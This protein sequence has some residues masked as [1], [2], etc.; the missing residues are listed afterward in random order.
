MHRLW[1][2]KVDARLTQQ[3]R[4][5]LSSNNP[6]LHSSILLRQQHRGH[7]PIP[8]GNDPD[9]GATIRQVGRLEP[10]SIGKGTIVSGPA[11]RA[12]GSPIPCLVAMEPWKWQVEHSQLGRALQKIFAQTPSLWWRVNLPRGAYSGG[13]SMPNHAPQP[14]QRTWEP[15][16]PTPFK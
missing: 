1:E 6:V 8:L 4:T 5:S 12:N 14:R 16:Q 11:L 13:G 7:R 15:P 2:N 3:G 9:L 10:V